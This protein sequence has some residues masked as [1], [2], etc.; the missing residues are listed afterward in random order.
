MDRC[1]RRISASVQA[2]RRSQ[3]MEARS[4]QRLVGVDVAD[5]GD[6]RL[7]EQERLQLRAPARKALLQPLHG[8]AAAQRLGT[9]AAEDL[10]DAVRATVLRDALRPRAAPGAHALQAAA[11]PQPD[12]PELPDVAV[13]ELAAIGQREGD[14]DVRVGRRVP[15]APRAARR[16]CGARPSS[17]GRPP[18]GAG[19]SS[20]GG[21]LAGSW[22][23]RSR[24][25]TAPAAADG[26]SCGPSGRS[27]R[28][29]W[30]RPRRD[31]DRGRRSRLRG[32]PASPKV[33]P[34][35][36]RSG[37]LRA[38][39]RPEP[40]PSMSCPNC[41]SANAPNRKFCSHCGAR[42]ATGVR[43]LWHARRRRRPVLRRVRCD[44][45]GG[46]RAT[47]LEH[48]RARRALDA[49]L[50]ATAGLGPVRRP[51]RLHDP[52]RD[53]RCRG[54]PRA[55]DPLLRRRSRDHRALRRRRREVHR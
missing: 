52:L 33:C 9:V 1:S 55:P 50:R 53:P 41:G 10:A 21:P 28:G 16:S 20:R 49:D 48:R 39:P 43:G 2:V 11:G 25:R 4:P 17:R 44:A 12:A 30:R 26:G 54:C 51:R 42:L 45:G 19:P 47:G 24:R 27:R 15:P 32:A 31:G 22:P 37:T 36:R 6:E 38:T 23:R 46:I 34:I 35:R 3:R 8:E 14:A 40:D 7:V 29:S 18:G 5:A 13:A